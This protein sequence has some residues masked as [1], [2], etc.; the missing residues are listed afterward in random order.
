M[1]RKLPGLQR[2]KRLSDS[3]T[4]DKETTDAFKT[5]GP[6]PRT[7]KF[8]TVASRISTTGTTAKPKA[9]TDDIPL[10][11]M[12]EA[13]VETPASEIPD[14]AVEI[15][16]ASEKTPAETKEQDASRR[17]AA[18]RVINSHANWASAGGI[19]PL[20]FVDIFAISGLQVRMVMRLADL[21]G[22]PF[23]QEAAKTIV[24]AVIGG[25]TPHVVTAGTVGLLFKSVPGF[26]ALVGVFGIASLA[27]ASTRVLGRVFV[28]HFEA[29][30]SLE[31][32]DVDALSDA[33]SE[34]ITEAQSA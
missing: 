4:E 16:D 30:R 28:A 1:S 26:G 12:E 31:V 10:S 32:V 34:G 24:A 27:N 17:L 18:Q 8:R 23:S 19:V 6:K 3:Y 14:E 29:G 5:A 11:A 2:V 21:Y 33:Y 7:S 25:V 20:P 9:V 22:V 13:P 15:I